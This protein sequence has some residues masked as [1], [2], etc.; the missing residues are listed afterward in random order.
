M[1]DMMI[2][3]RKNREA[4]DMF[5]KTGAAED[6]TSDGNEVSQIAR[7]ARQVNMLEQQGLGESAEQ[8]AHPTQIVQIDDFLGLCAHSLAI[9]P[10]ILLISLISLIIF[11][12]GDPRRA[13]EQSIG[14]G[15]LRFGL[16]A[17]I[18]RLGGLILWVGRIAMGN[19]GENLQKQLPGE[20]LNVNHGVQ[21]W[22]LGK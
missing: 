17:F 10:R 7:E 21:E 3:V 5:A 19:G 2:V 4:A 11:I 12:L 20:V 6:G 8:V 16:G 14:R 9:V 22:L 13:W 1:K 18:G 15:L